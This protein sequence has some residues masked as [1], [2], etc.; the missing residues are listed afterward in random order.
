MNDYLWGGYIEWHDKQITTFIDSRV[1][2]FER[3]GVLR[4]YLALIQI[5]QPTV[6]LD[7]YRIRYVFFP[8]QAP[9]MQFLEASGN[10]CTRYRDANAVLLERRNAGECR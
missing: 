6:L 10:W 7:R 2:I 9:L 8:P 5:H 4:D 1:D 3:R